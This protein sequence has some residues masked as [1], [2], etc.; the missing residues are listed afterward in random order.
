MNQHLICSRSSYVREYVVNG[1]V[2]QQMVILA[3]IIRDLDHETA[4]TETGR[5]FCGFFSSGDLVLN[6]E[7]FLIFLGTI[8]V[9]YGATLGTMYSEFSQ[10]LSRYTHNLLARNTLSESLQNTLLQ[11]LGVNP[12]SGTDS[13][14]APCTWPLQVYPR[15]LSVLAQV[16]I[17]DFVIGCL[18]SSSIRRY[19]C[20]IDLVTLTN[21]GILDRS[22]S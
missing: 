6:V 7:R 15:T 5:I 10:A 21:H 11:H 20:T 16:C 3:A 4:R 19:Y 2:E 8:S 14:T 18:L 13:T 9:F 17:V 12:W 22:S 1:L